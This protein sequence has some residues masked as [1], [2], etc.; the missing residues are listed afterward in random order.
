VQRGDRLPLPA[1]HEAVGEHHG[2]H[3]AG[4][5]AA[6]PVDEQPVVEHQALEHAPGEGAMRAAALQGDV[7]ALAL[8]VEFRVDRH[9]LRCVP[10]RLRPR[11]AGAIWLGKF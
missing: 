10:R 5:G 11:L 4:A 3:R 6:Q 9:D 2:V 7:D 1:A 8:L